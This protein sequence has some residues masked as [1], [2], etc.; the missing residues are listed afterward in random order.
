MSIAFYTSKMTLVHLMRSCKIRYTI[1]CKGFLQI[2]RMGSIYITWHTF[3]NDL[4][5]DNKCIERGELNCTAAGH[6]YI[7]AAT[8]GLLKLD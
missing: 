8:L 1:H 2:L 5:Y 6:L 4:I 7:T 3:C